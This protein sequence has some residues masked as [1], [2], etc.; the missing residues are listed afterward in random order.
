MGPLGGWGQV[1]GTDRYVGGTSRCEWVWWVGV[2]LVCRV[3]E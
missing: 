1:S 2:C 3:G